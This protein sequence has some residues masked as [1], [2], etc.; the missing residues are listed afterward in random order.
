MT[1]RRI[2]IGSSV[3]VLLGTGLASTASASSS[4]HYWTEAHAEKS[5]KTIRVHYRGEK[6]TAA[7]Q[8]NEANQRLAIVKQ[9]SDAC[10]CDYDELAQAETDQAL[11]QQFYDGAK[12]GWRVTRSHCDGRGIPNKRYRFPRFRC[13]I[14]IDHNDK[15]DLADV[16]L[17]PVSP[18]RFAY[19]FLS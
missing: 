9:E 17:R 10:Q 4:A 5:A 14:L 15:P 8:L 19:H 2:A 12:K 16:S 18:R 3:F 1:W 6:A 7:A 13:T 11:A